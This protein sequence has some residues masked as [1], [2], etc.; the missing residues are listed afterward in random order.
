MYYVDH[1]IKANTLLKQ[2]YEQTEEKNFLQAY[3][4]GTQLS[5]E[6]LEALKDINK[7]HLN[8]KMQGFYFARSGSWVGLTNEE[9]ENML[10]VTGNG[11]YRD[12]ETDRKSTRLNSSH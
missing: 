3:S 5:D 8:H 10:I 9:I 6:I 7:N 4:T 1:L 2:M 12:W 11:R